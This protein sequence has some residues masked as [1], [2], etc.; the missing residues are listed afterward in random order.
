MAETSTVQH[1]KNEIDSL[2]PT[3]SRETDL[4]EKERIISLV[5]RLYFLY[6]QMKNIPDFGGQNVSN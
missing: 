2:V 5:D 6:T 3:I 4:G 1:L